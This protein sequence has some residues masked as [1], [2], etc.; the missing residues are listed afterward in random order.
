MT[1]WGEG[2]GAARGASTVTIGGG[3]A[4]DY[5]IWTDTRITFQLGP[6]AKTGDIV[7]S[8]RTERER[9]RSGPASGSSNGIPFAVRPGKIYFVAVNGSDWRNGG[10]QAPWKSIVHAKDRMSAGDVTYIKNGVAQ[11]SEDHFTAYLSMDRNGGSNSGKPGAPKALVAYPGAHV[12]IGKAHGLDYGIRTP[13]I[14]ASEDYWV[15]S[16]LHIIGGRQAIDMSGTGWK[17]VGNDIECPGGDG[18]VGCVEASGASGLRFYGNEVHNAGAGPVASKF[19][20]AVYFSTDSSHIDVGW[21]HIHDNM[22]CRAVQFHSSPLCRPECGARDQTGHNQFD[23]HVHD[24]LIHGDSCN[25]INF[26]TVD[27]S[28]GPV[29][30][31]NNVIYHVGVAD[32]KDGGGAFSCIYVAGITNTGPAGT[33]TV[34]VFNNTLYD[35][36]ANR[37]R[38]SDGS[39]GAF[40]VAGGA[41]LTMHLR[42]NIVV[43]LQDEVYLDGKKAQIAGENNLWFGAGNGPAQTAGNINTD[44]Q[45]I[46][47]GKFDFHLRA[48][49]PARDAGITVLPNNPFVGGRGRAT[50]SGRATDKDGVV[51]PQGKA[52]DLGA[53][54]VPR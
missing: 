19:Y 34:E 5:P 53:Y 48:S 18:Q 50:D 35:C 42:N 24:N 49:S 22:T 28:K 21:N 14:N 11:T 31:Y 6:R 43:Q 26:A 27:P 20:H 36:G 8:V 47:L 45:F 39:R 9:T 16:Q 12:T 46:D 38:N 29:E 54:E 41:G 37:T 52:F 32:P 51:R 13:N 30:A 25:G 7:V 23:L 17:I 15:I 1:I 40:S 44:P 4:A 3:A 10:F 33:G 2:F